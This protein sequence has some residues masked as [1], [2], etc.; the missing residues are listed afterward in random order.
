MCLGAIYW[1]RLDAIYYGNNKKDAAHIG[2]DDA[3]IYEELDKELG[4]RTIPCTQL[5]AD[6]AISTVITSYSIHY[7]KLY[8]C[9]QHPFCYYRN[10]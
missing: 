7:T 10:K 2:F 9:V 8:E 6:K 5:L 1:S 3:F 4:K